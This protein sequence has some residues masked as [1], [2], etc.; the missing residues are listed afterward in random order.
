MESATPARP[1]SKP[2]LAP[3]TITG[4]HNI[5]GDSNNVTYEAGSRPDPNHPNATTCPQCHQAAWV[6]SDYCPCGFNLA[7][8]RQAR[9]MQIERLRKNHRGLINAFIV[10]VMMFAIVAYVL[11]EEVSPFLQV[12]VPI[13]R[14]L[15]VASGALAI[16]TFFLMHRAGTRLGD[17][18]NDL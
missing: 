4:H 1:T 15:L 18:S 17:A 11:I 3:V 8:E 2:G 12:F 6:A 5:V 13:F 16:I 9:Y 7:A 10:A 14:I